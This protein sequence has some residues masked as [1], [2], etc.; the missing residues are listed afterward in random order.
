MRTNY[1]VQIVDNPCSKAMII[2]TKISMRHICEGLA[3]LARLQKALLRQLEKSLAI[4]MVLFSYLF[5][6]PEFLRAWK[7]SE[8]F[9]M[10]SISPFTI[11]ATCLLPRRFVQ[12]KVIP[13]FFCCHTWISSF[14]NSGS[15]KSLESILPSSSLPLPLG[16]MYLLSLLVQ[17]I[18]QV[19]EECLGNVLVLPPQS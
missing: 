3:S 1:Y 17:T 10:S 8:Y 9:L 15:L 13:I 7:R 2:Y 18:Q 5:L 4:F 19:L 16:K 11:W 6:M 14:L 12:N